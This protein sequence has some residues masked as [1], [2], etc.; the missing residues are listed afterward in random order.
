MR[1]IHYILIVVIIGVII[2]IGNAVYKTE[3][4]RTTIEDN[5]AP[6]ELFVIDSHFRTTRIYDCGNLKEELDNEYLD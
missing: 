2:V 6:T 5:C 4:R 3:A 1:L